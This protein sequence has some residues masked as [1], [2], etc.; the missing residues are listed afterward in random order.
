[1]AT[2]INTTNVGLSELET[3]PG[4]GNQPVSFQ[5]SGRKGW[6]EG[7]LGDQTTPYF[8]WGY[9]NGG[10]G[11]YL[12]AIYG[13]NP[14]TTGSA[15]L[16][17]GDWRGLQYYFDGTD[18]EITVAYTNNFTTPPDGDV[19]V[20]IY[21]TDSAQAWSIFTNPLPV[22]APGTPINVNM[23]AATSQGAAP[24]A[25]FQPDVFP[26][27]KNVFWQIDVVT[28]DAAFPGGT[29][30]FDINGSNVLSDTLPPGANTT[31]FDYT[32]A[33]AVRGNTDASGIDLVLTVS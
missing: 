1:M 11:G 9:G 13:L 19:I 14:P 29:I 8:T 7:N 6:S 17:L 32:S 26:L 2:I 21:I 22:L 18:F 23:P 27:V 28:P 16:E 3:A 30:T 33:G 10:G 5:T 31:T 25:G 4:G 12:D 24:W 20:D 15:P